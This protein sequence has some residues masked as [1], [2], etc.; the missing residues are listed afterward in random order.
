VPE[1][2]IF[3]RCAECPLAKLERA[4][5]A[6]PDGRLLQAAMDIRAA[7]RMGITVRMDDLAA[8]EFYA[9]VVLEEE[10]RAFDAEKK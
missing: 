4:V 5:D 3:P 1:E 9:L 10:I 6:S 8:D 7:I 2:G